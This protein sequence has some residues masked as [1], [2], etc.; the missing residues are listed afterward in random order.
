VFNP[1]S[2]VKTY[3]CRHERKQTGRHQVSPL[4]NILSWEEGGK[5][6]AHCLELDIVAQGENEREALKSLA[7]LLVQQVEFAE[8][9]KME[10]F[11]PAPLEYWQKLYELH[12]NHVKQH[13]LENPPRSAKELLEGLEPAYA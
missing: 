7:E 5:H 12:S 4:M 2:E 8:G 1:E 13:L 9:N 11:H 3:L 6:F 10:I